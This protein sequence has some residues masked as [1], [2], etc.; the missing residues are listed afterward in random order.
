MRFRPIVL[1]VAAGLALADASVVTLALPQILRELHTTVEGVAAVIGV[2]TLVLAL[3]LIPLERAAAA[4]GTRTVGVAGFLLFAVASAACASANDIAGLLVAR[5]AQALGGSAGLV[6]AFAVIAGGERQARRLWLGTT[7]LATAIGPALG[8]ALTQAFDWRAIF[9]LQV[10]VAALGFLAARASGA[11]P[12]D[13]R[14]APLTELAI[15]LLFGALVGALFLAVL[16]LVAGW[17]YSPIHGALV[18]SALPLA[19][20]LTRRRDA[21]AGA[22]LLA[23]GLLA[24]AALPSAS[25]IFPLC[26]LALCG[27]GLGLA[28]PVLSERALAGG[29]VLTVAARHVGLVASLALVA[30]ILARDLP[31]AG[32]HAELQATKLV[33]ESPVGL[34]TKIPVALDL[35]RAFHGA[36]S[37]E[38]PD[39]RAPFD[40]HGARYDPSLARTRDR[41]SGAV[42]R[43]IAG[44]FRASFAVCAAFAAVAA[45]IGRRPAA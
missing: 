4:L 39:L 25:V 1:A 36:Q 33:L 10:P 5:G 15:A 18:V 17:R 41:L 9:V 27:T 35:G 20:L 40:A 30:P 43:T 7:V 38:V 42:D 23:S 14:P 2:Y 45:L 6:A 32:R 3:A 34:G 28:L 29:A 11:E 19:A 31:S 13:R 26:A 44:A 16:L 8:G 12:E 22:A 37:G 24:L 21:P